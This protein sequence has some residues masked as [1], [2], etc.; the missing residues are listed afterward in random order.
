MTRLGQVGLMF[1]VLGGGF[2]STVL[3]LLVVITVKEARRRR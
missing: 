3:T 1:G 2:L